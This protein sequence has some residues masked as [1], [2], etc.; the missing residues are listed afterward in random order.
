MERLRR[1]QQAH[2][3]V[4]EDRPHIPVYAGGIAPASIPTMHLIQESHPWFGSACLAGCPPIFKS[5][6]SSC[7]GHRTLWSSVNGDFVVP[8][9]RSATMQSRSFS[10]VGTTTW[11]ELPQNRRHLPN[12]ACSQFHQRLKTS[13]LLGLGQERL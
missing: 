12:G 4:Y 8:I 5:P 1:V 2:W 3:W 13:F 6:I 9:A 10:V 11:K 7:A